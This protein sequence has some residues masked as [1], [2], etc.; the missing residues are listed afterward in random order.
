MRARFG[1]LAVI[2]GLLLLSSRPAPAF[3][4]AGGVKGQDVMQP[5][6]GPDGWVQAPIPR[7]DSPSGSAPGEDKANKSAEAGRD[8]VPDTGKRLSPGQDPGT[9]MA[10]P[11]SGP[12]SAPPSGPRTP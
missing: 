12:A 9:P 2:T 10:A 1:C 11:A 4:Q 7:V 5:R 8:H 3:A 6:A